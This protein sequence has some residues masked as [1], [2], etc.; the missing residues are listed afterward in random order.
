MTITSFLRT[1]EFVTYIFTTTAV[2]IFSFSAYR[3]TK[4]RAFGFWIASTTIGI[5]EMSAWYIHIHRPPASHDDELTFN[6]I[7]RLTF[8]IVTILGTIGSVMIIKYFL[9]L[10]PSKDAR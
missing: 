3:R 6:V 9:K 2:L 4:L 5:I 8:I 1:V 7:Y 10:P